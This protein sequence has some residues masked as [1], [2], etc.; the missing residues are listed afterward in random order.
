M[1]NPRTVD[2]LV[3]LAYTS[4]A[5]GAMEHPFPIGMGLRVPHP[6]QAAPA[7]S[8]TTTTT[9]VTGSYA[10]QYQYSAVGQ[11]TTTLEP[12]HIEVDEDGLC[13][14]DQMDAVQVTL[15]CFS[16]YDARPLFRV[17]EG[18]YRQAHR[19]S[20]FGTSCVA[21]GLLPSYIIFFSGGRYEETS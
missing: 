17:D 18:M 16:F 8:N 4:A 13:E 10:Q 9:T 1:H 20:S 6:S 12:K 21:C 14:F 19:W 2:L 7:T 15:A 5:E 3:S 11:Q